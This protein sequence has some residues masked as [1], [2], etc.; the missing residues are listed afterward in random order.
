MEI[1]LTEEGLNKWQDVMKL[2]FSTLRFVREQGV[3]PGLG[4][5]Q[6]N[7]SLLAFQVCYPPTLLKT[8]STST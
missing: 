5:R 2:V 4:A 7:E 3:L 6:A 8:L 1:S